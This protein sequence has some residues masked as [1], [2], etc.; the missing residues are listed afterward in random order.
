MDS[1][2][3]SKNSCHDH[4]DPATY[5]M[6]DEYVERIEKGIAYDV[7]RHARTADNGSDNTKQGRDAA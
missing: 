5:C 6:N 7:S 1:I 4:A 3:L 2:L